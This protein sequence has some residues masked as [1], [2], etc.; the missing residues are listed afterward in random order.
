MAR[1]SVGI[2]SLAK[3]VN[4]NLL[5]RMAPVCTQSGKAR[6]RKVIPGIMPFLD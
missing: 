3:T 2:M 1:Y 6:P 5:N 4:P